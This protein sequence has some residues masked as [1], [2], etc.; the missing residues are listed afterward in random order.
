ML[1]KLKR[2]LFQFG[3]VTRDFIEESKKI[4]LIPDERPSADGII[5]VHLEGVG[6]S[7]SDQRTV[8]EVTFKVHMNGPKEGY[9]CII[10]LGLDTFP[11]WLY[12]NQSYKRL[13]WKMITEYKYDQY[14]VE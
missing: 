14:K 9:Y 1:F 11:F 10:F 2:E 12:I 13:V 7:I 6:Y 3:K 5:R 8:D 4:A